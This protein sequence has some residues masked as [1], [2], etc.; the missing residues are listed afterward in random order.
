[1]VPLIP[2]KFPKTPGAYI[3]GGSVRDL[4]LNRKPTDYDIAVQSEPEKYAQQVASRTSGRL[5]EI[6]KAGLKIIRV[7][8]NNNVFDISAIKG[9]SIEEDLNR[10]DFTINAMAYEIASGRLIDNLNGRRDL[11]A[12][13]I[14]M[15]SETAFLKD[16]L[17]LIRAFRIGACL[18]FIIENRTKA[19]IGRHAS[20]IRQTAGERIR[21]ELFKMFQNANCSLFL[22]QMAAAKLLFEIFPEFAILGSKESIKGQPV[23]AFEASLNAFENLEKILKNIETYIPQSVLPNFGGLNETRAILLKFVALLHDIGKP[24]KPFSDKKLDLKA[25][26]HE[27]KKSAAISVE[28]FKKL[29]FSNRHVDY[30]HAITQNQT[31]PMALFRSFQ[32]KTLAPID[33][34]RFFI[35][36]RDLI[37]DLLFHALA[38]MQ[39]NKNGTAFKYPV[40]TDFIRSLMKT[41]FSVFKPR[42]AMPRLIT[43]HDLIE[44]F[45]LQPSPQFKSILEFVE[46]KRLSQEN[47]TRS[48]AI[49]LV[50]TFLKNNP[51]QF[52]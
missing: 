23:D 44:A 4:L 19:A 10:R 40:F 8:S 50:N 37:P 15:V 21:D 7:I 34:T 30:I 35:K 5:V 24:T 22:R 49:E 38:R 29:R 42:A 39:A 47:L 18:D 12:K 41:Y 17:R 33:V 26:G 9:Q 45:G 6:G 52:A 3:V 31:E 25:Y 48:E 14:R 11:K 51:R 43:G 28:I 13:T 1:M 16:P 2:Y 32:N 27:E 20:L 36:C 46:E